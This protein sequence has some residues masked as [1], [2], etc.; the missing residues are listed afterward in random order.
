MI[1]RSV[2]WHSPAEWKQVYSFLYSKDATLEKLGVNRVKC[3]SAR[4]RL[5]HA[6]ESTSLLVEIG[7]QDD[8]T[9]FSTVSPREIQHLLAIAIIRFVNGIVDSAQKGTVAASA[10][11]IAGQVGLPL[12]FV[13]LRHSATHDK[14]PNLQTLRNARAQSLEWLDQ[15]YWRVQ[16]DNVRESS[17]V[18]Q[19]L[20]LQYIEQRK[21]VEHNAS[22][23]KSAK[24][25]KLSKIVNQ[26]LNSM[27]S[28]SYPDIFLPVLFNAPEFW[29]DDGFQGEQSLK[30][31]NENE[32]FKLQR[33]WE[34]LLKGMEKTWPG[35]AEILLYGII[36]EISRLVLNNDACMD[37]DCISLGKS[38]INKV[39]WGKYLIEEFMSPW[40]NYSVVDIIRRILSSPNNL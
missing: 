33:F 32:N 19:A 25:Q 18:V 36:E 35:F 6:I 29:K 3:W 22:E 31:S 15:Y 38:L 13:E 40:E 23:K 9:R 5:P 16:E 2:P 20:I 37:S 34:P 27:S 10:S 26:I 30:D 14:L 17:D 39:V 1:P 21:E 12:W 11:N 28:N 7:L 24:T 8:P 4:G